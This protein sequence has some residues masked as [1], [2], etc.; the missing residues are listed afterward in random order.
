MGNKNN[1][2]SSISGSIG[3]GSRDESAASNAA[4]DDQIATLT[5]TLSTLQ[6]SLA[7][8]DSDLDKLETEGGDMPEQLLT[9]HLNM[10]A[11]FKD[12]DSADELLNLLD[13][14]FD[15]LNGKLDDLLSS[16][17]QQEEDGAATAGTADQAAT[18]A[19]PDAKPTSQDDATTKPEL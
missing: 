8:L 3:G 13:G 9:K 5:R 4:V 1:S 11:I 16:L 14:R 7:G 17:E 18:P 12:M 10:Q 2:N 6:S 15:E 19:T